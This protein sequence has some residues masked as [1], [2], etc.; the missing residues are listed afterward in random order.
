[1]VHGEEA[2]ERAR[3]ASEA[4]FGQEIS[5]LSDLELRE[6]FSEAPSAELPRSALSAGLTLLELLRKSGACASNAEAKRLIHGGGAYLN[7]RRS[8]DPQGRVGEADLASESIL[9]LR[10][11]KTEYRL[12]KF[13]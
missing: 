7:N 9:V 5:G 2:A 6:A 10:T 4:L 12:V 11:G 13:V 8:S 1:L 3:R